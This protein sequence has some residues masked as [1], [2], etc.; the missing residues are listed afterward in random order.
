MSPSGS[1]SSVTPT[2]PPSDP[3]L[4]GAGDIATEGPGDDATAALLDG[5][6][7]T[8]FT[9][10][11]NV[12][13]SG[14]EAEYARWYEPTWGRH[15]SRTRPSPGNHDYLTAGAAAYFQYFGNTAGIPGQGYYSYEL[16]SWHIVA[17]NSNIAMSAGSA[18]ERWLRADLARHPTRCT[19]AYWHHPLFTSGKNHPPSPAT[20]PL[21]QALY[22]L[23]ADV[24]VW[25]H[26]HQYERFA[27]QDPAGRR[28]PDHGLRAFVAG[29]GGASH[30][31]FGPVRANSEARNGD[32]FG[33]LAFTLHTDGYDWRFVPEAG[34]SYTDSGAGT[35][36]G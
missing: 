16:G 27:P 33:V 9:T 30:Y 11:D 1:P 35:C 5:I 3:V 29:T 28:D 23:G 34:L 24:V 2:V 4:V 14:T 36:H 18:Q 26:N 17:L 21:Y 7:G 22:D 19:L 8:V 13:D 6:A 25:G 31:G 20:R 10:G 15:R 32:T 12:Y